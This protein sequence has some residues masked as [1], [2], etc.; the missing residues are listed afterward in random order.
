M[1]SL[2]ELPSSPASVRHLIPGLADPIFDGPNPDMG[3]G[4]GSST[5][6]MGAGLVCVSRHEHIDAQK[7]ID[8]TS[9]G[10]QK[11]TT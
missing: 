10:G 1:S 8:V 6:P 7:L 4:G 3:C 2:Q 5:Y 11:T 9:K